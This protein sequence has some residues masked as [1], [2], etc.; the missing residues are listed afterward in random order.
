MAL[1]RRWFRH[2]FRPGGQGIHD[3]D[4][5]VYRRERTKSDFVGTD[6]SGQ[7]KSGFEV[8]GDAQ[9]EDTELGFRRH[10]PGRQNST[11]DLSSDTR[12][13]GGP[14]FVG[15]WKAGDV[16]GASTRLKITTDGGNGITVEAPEYQ[17][18]C[19]GSFDGKDY[20]VIQT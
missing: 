10:Q 4:R 20:P 8:E 18:I 13:S 9:R 17:S 5:N 2:G 6:V 1:Q 3:A 11:A 12:V 15:K 16:K 7:R 19:K 14:G